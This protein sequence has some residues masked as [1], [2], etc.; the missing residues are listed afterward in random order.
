MSKLLTDNRN[1]YNQD[2]VKPIQ[3]ISANKPIMRAA[4]CEPS[5]KIA[6]SLQIIFEEIDDTAEN[7]TIV[8]RENLGTKVK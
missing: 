7:A 6:F 4:L 3:P 8:N 2:A 1:Y 5:P